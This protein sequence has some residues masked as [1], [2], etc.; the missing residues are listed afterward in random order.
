MTRNKLDLFW[1]GGQNTLL[2]PHAFE[3]GGMI[4]AAGGA[5]EAARCRVG[6]AWGNFRE[7]SPFFDE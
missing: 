3:W 1:G 2:A 6:C 7:L 4:S 5:K